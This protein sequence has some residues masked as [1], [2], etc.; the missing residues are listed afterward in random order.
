M[1][2]EQKKSIYLEIKDQQSKQRLADPSNPVV[3]DASALGLSGKGFAEP[4]WKDLYV[5]DFDDSDFP[6]AKYMRPGLVVLK[7]ITP[8]DTQSH[9]VLNATTH[10]N[11]TSIVFRIVHKSTQVP[12]KFEVGDIVSVNIAAIDAMSEQAKYA[13]VSHEDIY[14][15]WD[16]ADLKE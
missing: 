13:V 6:K 12:D 10:N 7:A 1:S 8:E 15:G 4:R 11:M 16:E 5:N 14:M 2:K 3:F 9:K